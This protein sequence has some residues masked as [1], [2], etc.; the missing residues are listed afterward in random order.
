[1]L[2]ASPAR[3]S[4][5]HGGG[6]GLVLFPELTEL[7]PLLVL[8]VLLIPLVNHLLFKPVFRILDARTERIDGARRRAARLDQDAAGVLERYRVAVA[9]V[10]SASDVERKAT[11]ETA[12]RAHVDLVAAE[13]SAAERRMDTTRRE[14]DSALADARQRLRQDVEALAHEAAARI[15]GR[16]LS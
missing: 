13:R 15:L 5:A 3:A 10:R 9:E 7:V 2:A 1:M 6:H 12:R 8:F 14:I 11:L 16:A 4:D